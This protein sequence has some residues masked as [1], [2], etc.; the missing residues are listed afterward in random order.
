MSLR[1]GPE[2]G[3][4]SIEWSLRSTLEETEQPDA[5]V[6][7]DD[8]FGVSVRRVDERAVVEMTG[9]LDLYGADLAISAARAALEAQ[10]LPT[11]LEIGV[12]GLGFVDSS[13]LAALLSIRELAMGA[14]VPFAITNASASVRRV[15]EV[16][17]LN[18][19][20]FPSA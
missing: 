17:G 10:P 8:D 9:E 19:I 16:S 14:D 4:S 15:V 1:L 5:L 20:F 7:G 12:G 3:L 6:D 11:G 18:D 13:G 2:C